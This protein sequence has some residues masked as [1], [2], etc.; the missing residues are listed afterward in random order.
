MLDTILRPVALPP[1]LLGHPAP[2]DFFDA[3]GTLLLK[4]G[5]PISPRAGQMPSTRRLFCRANQARRIST[6]DPIA[7]LCGVGRTLIA[8]AERIVRR[9]A[10]DG[11]IFVEL[12]QK[13]HEIWAL[14]AD[15]CIG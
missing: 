5:I 6:V 2:C 11:H 4:A 12:A 14:D 15:A 7:Q 3:K 13:V 8:L 1:H 9:E 10:V